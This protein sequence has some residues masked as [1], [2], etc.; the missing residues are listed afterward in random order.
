MP[1]F[2]AMLG[3]P[4]G[5]DGGMIGDPRTAQNPQVRSMN[6]PSPD[7]LGGANS[8]YAL[9]QLVLQLQAEIHEMRSMPRVMSFN[10]RRDAD[11]RIAGID[12]S[13]G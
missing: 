8:I 10:V 2:D 11:G 3:G 4:A 13:E 6:P 5:M 9:H 7:Q 1:M 12:A